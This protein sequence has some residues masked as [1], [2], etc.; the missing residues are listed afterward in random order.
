M[1]PVA[2]CRD[3]KLSF[4]HLPVVVVVVLHGDDD[5]DCRMMMAFAASFQW[6]WRISSKS[7]FETIISL[8]ITSIIIIP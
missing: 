8:I 7:F 4:D 3:N 1:L 6:S 2:H 5:D